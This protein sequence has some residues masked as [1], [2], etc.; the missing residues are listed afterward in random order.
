MENALFDDLV[1]SLKEAKE[2]SKSKATA[3]RRFQVA[4]PDVKA[5][6]EQLGLHKASFPHL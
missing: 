3:S 2:I 4:P 5:L 1:Q 6:R